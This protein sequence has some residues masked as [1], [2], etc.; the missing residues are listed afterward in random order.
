LP[1]TVYGTMDASK[2]QETTTRLG[3]LGDVRLPGPLKRPTPLM[4]VIKQNAQNTRQHGPVAGW[5]L[6]DERRAIVRS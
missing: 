6:G 1:T 2:D 3:R 5:D 4:P